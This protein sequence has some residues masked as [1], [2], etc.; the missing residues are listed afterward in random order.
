MMHKSMF[1]ILT[2]V[3]IDPEI[4]GVWLQLKHW[5]LQQADTQSRGGCS[6]ILEREIKG[7]CI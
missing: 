7:H 6:W 1:G 4:C 5:N 3:C 2:K